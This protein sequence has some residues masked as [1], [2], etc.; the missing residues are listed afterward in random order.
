[1]RL[2]AQRLRPETVLQR[3]DAARSRVD[4]LDRL[5]RSLDPDAPLLRGYVL[6]TDAAGWVVKT[7]AIAAEES[8]LT[9]KF[10]DG[11]L[12]VSPRATRARASPGA[13]QQPKL[14]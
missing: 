3:I 8:T 7:R 2:A 13:P 1:V 10:A 4:A 6:V 9:L 11:T 12:T 5:R 14:L